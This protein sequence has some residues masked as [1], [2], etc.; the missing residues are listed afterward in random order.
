VIFLGASG[1]GWFRAT[2]AERREVVLPNLMT[3]F[4]EWLEMGAK[5]LATVDDDLFMVGPPGAPDFTWYLIYEVPK[6]ETVAAMI[7]RVRTSR[8]GM[9]LDTY[10][11]LEARIGRPFFPVEGGH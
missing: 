7:H 2:D 3:L 5:P 6:L 10:F 1:E 4:K 8:D 11:R 9:R